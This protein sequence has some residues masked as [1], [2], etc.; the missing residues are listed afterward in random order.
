LTP[1][2]PDWPFTP[3]IR[4]LIHTR[5]FASPLVESS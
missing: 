3:Q 1:D 4:S 5:F 2:L